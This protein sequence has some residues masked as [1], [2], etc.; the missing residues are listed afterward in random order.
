MTIPDYFLMV[1]F[2]VTDFRGAVFLMAAFTCLASLLISGE[3]WVN[4][5]LDFL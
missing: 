2:L 3:D 4:I 5:S 1:D